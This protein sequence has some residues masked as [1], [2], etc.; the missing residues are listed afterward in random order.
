MILLYHHTHYREKGKMR[1]QKKIEAAAA[2]A[3]VSSLNHTG[4]AIRKINL[5]GRLFK[6]PMFALMAL[7][8]IVAGSA[9]TVLADTTTMESTTTEITDRRTDGKK[10]DFIVLI[11]EQSTALYSEDESG[12]LHLTSNQSKEKTSTDEE[13]NM[14][15]TLLTKVRYS[16]IKMP[17]QLFFTTTRHY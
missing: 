13:D 10:E 3:S 8:T 2:S 17:T 4:K 9:P 11:S 6:F 5:A 14:L 1:D 15:A 7:L 16:N 12:D